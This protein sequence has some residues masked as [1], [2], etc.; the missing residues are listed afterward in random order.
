MVARTWG[1]RRGYLS[2]RPLNGGMMVGGGW[3]RSEGVG[4]TL[5]VIVIK[6]KNNINQYIKVGPSPMGWDWNI[7]RLDK[8]PRC[9][10]YMAAILGQ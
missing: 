5:F 7:G 10:S 4:V 1:R 8:W 2:S 9:R 3:K 6:K